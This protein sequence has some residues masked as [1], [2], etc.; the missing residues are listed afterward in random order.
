MSDHPSS[1][2][3]QARTAAQVAPYHRQLGRTERAPAC[4]H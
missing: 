1:P 3:V 4:H 2:Q